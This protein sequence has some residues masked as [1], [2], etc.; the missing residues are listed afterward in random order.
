[1]MNKNT[2]K[3]MSIV[4]AISV[5]TMVGC[6]QKTGTEPTTTPGVAEKAGA[7]LDKAADK[8]VEGTGIAI[9]KTGEAVKNA[10][11][12]VEKTGDNMQK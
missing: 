1:M 2:M 6:K 12:S 4:A 5:V 11:A 10:A 8:T 7:A 3:W 9:E